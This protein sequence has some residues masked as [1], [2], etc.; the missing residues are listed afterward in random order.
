MPPAETAAE[1]V[2]RDLEAPRVPS[3]HERRLLT[4]LA[5]AVGEPLLR[6]QLATVLVDAVCRCGCSSVRLRTEGEPVPAAMAARSS[7]TGRDDHVA[8]A[9]TGRRPEQRHVDV[10][11]HVM[12]GRLGELEVFHTAAGE[13]AAVSLADLEDLAGPTV[14]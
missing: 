13:G 6:G 11:L 4:A 12:A 5:D 10:V 2:W 7:G 8:V 1:P 14:G 9:A 3:A